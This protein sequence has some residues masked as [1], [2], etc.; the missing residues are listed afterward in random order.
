MSLATDEGNNIASLI[1]R[2]LDMAQKIQQIPAPTFSEKQRGA[3]VEERF[4]SEGLR[5]VSRDKIGNV[6]AC[7]PGG[8]KLAP[9]VISAHLDTVFPA[10]T[11]L[12][13]RRDQERIY[14]PGIGDNSMGVAGL[15]G[16]LWVLRQ[17]WGG[18][19]GLPGDIWLVANVGEEGLGDLC[20]MSAVVDRYGDRPLAYLV[21]EGMALGQ[22]YHRALGVQRYR[23]S[24]HTR[25]GH[26]WV[27]YGAPSAIHELSALV[28]RLAAL[29][30]PEAPR[31]SLN[32]GV[33]SGGTSVNTIAPEATIE[34]DLRSEGKDALASLIRQVE[35]LTAA[36]NRA[37]VQ[38]SMEIIGQRPSGEIPATH[39]LVSLAQRNLQAQGIQPN[40]TIGSTDAN[41]P[42]SRG[43]PAICVGISTGHGAH[44]VNEYLDIEPIGR[45][46]E[47]LIGL[48]EGAFREL[49]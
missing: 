7:M 11:N 9:L 29:P 31:S 25:G 12:D 36:V 15:F 45:G 21:L 8:G 34:L 39:P 14:G 38:A 23:I 44:T 18:E 1:P 28:T 27:D 2:I 46:L 4:Q 35:A 49:A 17:R 32:V 10:Q 47:F 22:I 3:F 37:G 13:V 19:P 20:G 6:Y 43:L 24:V 5:D 48:V 42:L 26:S 33:I 40:L 30:V 41:I 16:L